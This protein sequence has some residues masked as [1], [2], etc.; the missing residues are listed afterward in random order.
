MKLMGGL[1]GTLLYLEI[2]YHLGCFGLSAGNPVF[3]LALILILASLE[4]LIIEGVREKWRKRVF[5]ICMGLQYV[6]FAVQTIYMGIFKQPLLWEAVVRGGKDALTDYWRETLS[7]VLA[8]SVYLVLMAL[9][10]IIAGILL[11]RGSLRLAG[12]NSIM[13][14]RTML[15]AGVGVVL[16]VTII[17]I[18]K[19]TDA[20]Y[21]EEYS[22]FYDPLTVAEHMGMLTMA[23]QDTVKSVIRLAD[24]LKDAIAKAGQGTEPQDG[25][26]EAYATYAAQEGQDPEISDPEIPDEEDPAVKDPDA[27]SFNPEDSPAEAHGTENQRPEDPRTDTA[28]N[29]LPFDFEL[30]K[31]NADCEE[32]AWLAGYMEAQTPTARNEYTGIFEGYNLIFLTAEGF[33]PYA[34]SEELTP[35]LYRL[36]HAGLDFTNYYVPLWQTSTSDGEYIN[37]TGLIPDG[38]YSM[39]KSSENAMP[40]TLPRYF[41][42]Q[43]AGSMAYHNNSLSYYD[44]NVTHNNLG[45]VFK[46]ARLGSVSE[47]EGGGFLFPME[48]PD[49]WP[50]SDLEMMQG[51][52]PEYIGWDRFHVYYMTVS[53]HMNYNFTG[54]AMSAKNKEAVAGLEMS[55]TARAYIACQIELDKALEYLIAQL[56]EAGK[57]EN[58]VICLS[59][60]H[61]PYGMQQTEYEELAGHSL[62]NDLDLYRSSLILWNVRL[63]ENPMTVDKVCG[64]MDL[65]PTLLNLFGFSYDSRL[66]AGK[67][68][69]SG[70]EGMVIFNDRS[71]IT[72][73]V[74]YN[75]KNK[76]TVWRKELPDEE[77]RLYLEQKKQEVKDRYQFSAYILRKDYYAAAAEALPEEYRG[78]A[79][80][81]AWEL[82]Q[83]ETQAGAGGQNEEQ[84]NP[85]RQA[86]E[87][88]TVAGEPGYSSSQEMPLDA[89]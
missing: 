87:R 49:A 44:R 4:R 73:S 16:A 67:D 59:A 81:P 30:L 13:R 54:N 46:A 56:D 75:R 55:E 11:R 1:A 35:T 15:C 78:L 50:A 36:I 58:T 72:D 26:Q 42:A 74:V 57:L 66:Y 17:L 14:L 85:E 64:S 7:G 77:A 12:L 71:F 20:D 52:I 10:L 34:V 40:F 70:D 47:Q 51:T 3:T 80:N 25:V 29:Q 61:Y 8:V 23:Q 2:V 19:Y 22:E 39:R 5:W 9:P 45:Y 32:T 28:P 33:S 31:A 27:E 69:F 83:K 37:C 89:R 82:L 84:E 24:S 43:G 65:L 53:G 48:H 6:L 21:Y 18:G 38:Q 88:Q 79:V 60:D 68:I 41:A 62:S 63:E 76:S 86:E